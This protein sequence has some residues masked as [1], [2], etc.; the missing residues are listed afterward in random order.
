MPPAPPAAT[1]LPVTLSDSSP[2]QPAPTPLDT[3][4]AV[5]ASQVGIPPVL[6][7][8]PIL[9]SSADDDS[10]RIMLTQA[11]LQAII[12]VH[13]AHSAPLADP[14]PIVAPAVAALCTQGTVTFEGGLAPGQCPAKR[15]RYYLPSANS[16]YETI[17]PNAITV[18]MKIIH[19]F[20]QGMPQYIPLSILTACACREAVCTDSLDRTSR[21]SLQ[22]DYTGITVKA[23]TFDTSKEGKLTP[24]E[25]LDA[26]GHFV[27]LTWKHLHAG[28]DT[29]P[30]GPTAR[31]LAD[32]WAIHFHRIQIQSDFEGHFAI[33]LEYDMWVRQ[34]F[35]ANPNAFPPDVWHP[36]LYHALLDNALCARSTDVGKLTTSSST[37]FRAAASSSSSFC[38]SSSS[39]SSKPRDGE[40]ETSSRCM[41]CG[42]KDHPFRSCPGGSKAKLQKNDDG[43]WRDV[44]NHTYCINFN[45][46]R[47]CPRKESCQHIHACSLCLC[48]DHSAQT[49]TI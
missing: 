33:Y 22:L 30:G 25:W 6:G 16:P 3:H 45:G 32:L 1:I 39:G 8:R 12:Q 24:L 44:E 48:R 42:G 2:H 41:Y 10:D 21:Q 40:R 5:P 15:C 36:E 29:D 11:E 35:V 17:D 27:H 14:L 4:T 31:G 47:A 20:E 19:A 38:T 28:D 37:S 46:P 23:T 49:C 18:P 43:I 7:K 26:L 34:Q 9:A 13:T